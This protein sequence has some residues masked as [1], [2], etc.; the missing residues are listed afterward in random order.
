MGEKEIG[1]KE[2]GNRGREKVDKEKDCGQ[3]MRKT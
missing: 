1:K 3:W 2:E